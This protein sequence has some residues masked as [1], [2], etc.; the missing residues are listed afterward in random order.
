MSK[1]NSTYL[2]E[3]E[4]R[5][6]DR[7]VEKWE[8]EW[9]LS[10]SEEIELRRAYQIALQRLERFDEAASAMEDLLNLYSNEELKSTKAVEDGRRCILQV[11]LYFFTFV[12]RTCSQ[13]CLYFGGVFTGVSITSE[14]QGGV[15]KVQKGSL[16][17]V[18]S[19]KISR[20][21]SKKVPL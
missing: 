11:R 7:F 4:K 15:Y 17:K 13:R 2:L 8:K 19:S 1:K 5:K 10:K 16:Y 6:V 14:L 20:F 21:F 18:H 9:G 3:L 12:N